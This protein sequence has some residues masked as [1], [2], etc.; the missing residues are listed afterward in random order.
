VAVTLAH[1][2]RRSMRFDGAEEF[3]LMIA[4]R[5]HNLAGAEVPNGL[6][7]ELGISNDNVNTSDDAQDIVSV[8]L[9]KSLSEGFEDVTRDGVYSSTV[10]VYKN[11]LKGGDH[12]TWEM[13]MNPLR[14]TGAITLHPAIMYRSLE[15]EPPHA[16]WV[17]A[18][19]AKR[20]DED[21]S[22]TSGFSQKSG[23]SSRADS[24]GGG[25]N[26]GSTMEQKE[27]IV[28]QCQQITLSPMVGLVPCPFVFFR[29]GQGDLDCFRF[30]WSVSNNTKWC[31]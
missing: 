12:V 24:E 11:E 20:E 10:A 13:T 18:S 26:D 5:V 21:T 31:P 29:D 30:L 16:A 8:E 28:I 4:M 7:L 19:D 25:D 17:T 3:R 14:M 2:M 1:A 9:L 6:R 27:N 23:G 22:V 15:R